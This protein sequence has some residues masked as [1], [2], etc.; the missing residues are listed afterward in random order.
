MKVIIAG[1]RTIN[2]MRIVHGAVEDS[3]WFDE[4]TEVVSGK[5]PDGVD[6]LGEAL[7]DQFDIPIK[8]FPADWTKYGRAAGPI[9]NRQMANYADA[10]ILVWDGKSSGSKSMLF[11]A[12]KRNLKIYQRL[13]TDGA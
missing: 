6:M 4:I 2:D 7:A 11:E 8:P 13:V 12:Q 3:G 9:R 10:L 1:S 5:E